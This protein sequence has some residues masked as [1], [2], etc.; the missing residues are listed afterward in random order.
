MRVQFLRTTDDGEQKAEGEAYIDRNG[1]VRLDVPTW[2]QRELRK[3]G[4]LYS[5]KTWYPEDG[6]EF[7]NKL[8]FKYSGSRFRANLI[9]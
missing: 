4:I 6:E 2:T 7:L 9:E 3:Y 8:P 1:K 5:G